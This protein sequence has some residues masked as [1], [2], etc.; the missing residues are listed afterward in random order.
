MKGTNKITKSKE[1][2]NENENGIETDKQSSSTPKI[3]ARSRQNLDGGMAQREDEKEFEIQQL[4]V[5]LQQ[6]HERLEQTQQAL[7]HSQTE[8]QETSQAYA[9]I[10][11]K[12][13]NSI[14]ITPGPNVNKPRLP[15]PQD[16]DYQTASLNQGNEKDDNDQDTS[17]EKNILKIFCT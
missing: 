6:Q 10:S 7:Q 2:K 1:I 16:L 3:S 12:L 13:S 4:R 11:Q 9:E 17:E 5:L 14:P 15:R 8:R